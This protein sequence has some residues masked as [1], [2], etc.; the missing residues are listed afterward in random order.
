MTVAVSISTG[1]QLQP[2][3]FIYGSTRREP[4]EGWADMTSCHYC[5]NIFLFEIFSQFSFH[6]L[7]ISDVSHVMIRVWSFDSCLCRHPWSKQDVAVTWCRT[8]SKQTE[9]LGDRNWICSIYL[10]VGE[11]LLSFL[12]LHASM[13]GMWDEARCLIK[14]HHKVKFHRKS[15]IILPSF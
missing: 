1:S 4:Q 14:K 11:H 7:P 2:A 5:H 3:G 15:M 8:I 13:C 6:T 10:K 9:E 12:S